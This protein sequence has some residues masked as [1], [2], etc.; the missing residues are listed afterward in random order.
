MEYNTDFQKDIWLKHIEV[1]ERVLQLNSAPI[2][3]EPDSI[4]IFGKRMHLKVCQTDEIDAKIS[5][6]KAFFNITDDDINYVNDTLT[7]DNNFVADI[8]AISRLAED[9]QKYYIQLSKNP[10]ID[11]VIRSRK[12]TFS[13]CVKALKELNEQYAVDN[14]GRLQVTVEALRKL[15]NDSSFPEN[16]LPDTASGIFGISP[17]PAYFLRKWLSID[18]NH[19]LKYEMIKVNGVEERRLR[20]LL[21]LND[22]YLNESSLQKLNQLWGVRFLSFDVAVEVSQDILKHYNNKDSLYDFSDPKKGIY[23][24]HFNV[25]SSEKQDNASIIDAKWQ[26]D[27][28]RDIY[29]TEFGKNSYHLHIKYNYI[30]DNRLFHQFVDGINYYEFFQDLK[31][32]IHDERISISESKQSIGIDFDWRSTCPDNLRIELSNMYDDMEVSI[33]SGH[34]CNVDICDKNADWEKIENFLKQNY[35]SLKTYISSKD[36]SMHYVQEYHTQEQASQFRY[37][38]SA[39]LGE[40]NT[41]GCECEIHT[42]PAGKKKYLLRIDH[43]KIAENKENVVNSLRGVEFTV[44]GRS[45][46]KLFKV[47]FPELLFDISSAEYDFSEEGALSFN[48]ITPNLEGD[49]EKIKRLKDAFDSIVSGKGVKNPKIKDFIFDA[50]KATPTKDIDYFTNESSDYYQDIKSNLLNRHI[51]PSQLNAIIKCLRADDISLI[52]GPP[53]TGK[54]TA[55]AELIWQHIR[56]N[57]KER[58]L[59]TSETNLAVDNA[60]DRTVNSTHNLVKPIRFGSDDRLAVEGKQFSVAAMEQWVATG[61]YEF[62]D[63]FEESLEDKSSL[64]KSGKMILV[65]WLDNIK[66]RIDYDKMDTKSALLWEQYLA[67]P[68]KQL[69]ELIFEEYKSHCNVIGATCSSIGEKNTK[70]RPTKFFMNYC[71]VFGEVSTKTVYKKDS[72][73]FDDENEIVITNYKSKDGITFS[74]VIQD[75]SSKATPA[76]LALPLIYGKKNIVIGDHRQLPPMLDKEEFINT[77]DFLIDNSNGETEIRQLKKLKSY[78]IRNFK[79]MEISHF[80]RIFEN[81]DESLKGEFTLQ[82]RM[83]PDIN[84]VIKQFYT[85]DKGLECGLINPVDLGVNDVDMS[86]P[87]SRYHGISIDNFICG[88]SLTPDNHVI[89]IDVNSPEMVEGTSRINEG[90]VDVISHIL[91]KFSLSDSFREYSENWTDDDDKEI[92][93]ISF[94]SKQRN[95]IKKMCKAFNN[96]PLKIDVV[97]RFQGM[98]RNIIIVSMVRSNT[99]VSDPQQKPD[100]SEYVLGYPEQTDLGFAQSPNRLNVAL[101][102]ARR[103]LIIVGNSELFRQKEIYNNVYQIIEANSNGKIIKCNPYEDIRR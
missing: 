2:V 93:I 95:R 35:S 100:F 55:I 75:E 37:S 49:I 10:I 54:S 97:D 17:T 102:R 85:E 33:F 88:E 58:I 78:V 5:S 38:L 20:R 23:Y 73:A 32:T 64:V 3:I 63:E 67:N 43:N 101:S 52:Q 62:V 8:D 94:Y 6:I 84:E 40:L 4:Q 96:L 15:D 13:K 31:S 89:W 46:G 81:I 83:H 21:S 1:Q 103:L 7:C 19:S 48:K 99:I 80:Q 11:G 26:I 41:M 16:A 22:S 98:E 53:G 30:Y 24:Y 36:G 12:S 77:L 18:C 42:C 79:E 70:N 39:S 59:L 71:T 86:N 14:N 51:N 82:Y 27:L 47:I 65:N 44:G 57:P 92:G 25:K 68:D 34:K 72:D 66:K 28:L 91:E 50:K 90:E 76:E 45:I 56:L 29:D 69:R 9:C 61:K 60:I 87:F 74:T